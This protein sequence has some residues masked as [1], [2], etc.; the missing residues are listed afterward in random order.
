[1]TGGHVL[2]LRPLDEQVRRL[3]PKVDPMADQLRLSATEHG[4]FRRSLNVQ[5]PSVE[6]ALDQIRVQTRPVDARLA[7]RARILDELLARHH[8]VEER[9]DGVEERPTGVVQRLDG[10]EQ[11]LDGVERGLDGIGCELGGLC[12]L[13]VARLGA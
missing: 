11:G 10:T 6:I 3:L 9:L 4:R 2:D 12:A 1:M 7:T 5:F 8:R 13:L